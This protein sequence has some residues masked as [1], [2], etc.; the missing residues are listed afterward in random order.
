MTATRRTI[1][2][3][4]AW[5]VPVLAVAPAAPA[6]AASPAPEPACTWEGAKCPGSSDTPKGWPKHGYLLI[7]DCATWDVYLPALT[8]AGGNGKPLPVA[9]D[10]QGRAMHGA[11]VDGR[12]YVVLDG[13]SSPETVRVYDATGTKIATVHTRPHCPAVGLSEPGG[14]FGVR[15]YEG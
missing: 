6:M 13:R 3:G 5:A 9:V 12:R 2:K 10:E 1:V 7:A 15:K 4:A 8:Y 14:G 11:T